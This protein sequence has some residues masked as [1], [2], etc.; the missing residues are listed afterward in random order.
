[1]KAKAAIDRA[2]AKISAPEEVKQDIKAQ[3]VSEVVDGTPIQYAA[4]QA[5]QD[6]LDDITDIEDLL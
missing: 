6:N 5:I 4:Q 1:M 3:I 2:V